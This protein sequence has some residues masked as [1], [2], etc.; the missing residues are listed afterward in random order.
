MKVGG[1]RVFYQSGYLSYLGSTGG[2]CVGCIN[3]RVVLVA[4]EESGGWNMMAR[5]IG[6]GAE[7]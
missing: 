6:G 5:G 1:V 7:G 4:I 3:H 2:V